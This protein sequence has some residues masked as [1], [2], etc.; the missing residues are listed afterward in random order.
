MTCTL[1]TYGSPLYAWYR[2]KDSDGGTF[3][4]AV[5]GGSTTSLTTATTPAIATQN[6]GTTGWGLIRVTGLVAGSHNIVF[7]VTSA[8]S[9]SNTVTPIAVGTLTGQTFYNQPNLFA[10]GVPKQDGDGNAVA[11][12]AYNADALSDATLLSGDGLP[13]KFVDVRGYLCTQLGGGSCENTSGTADMSNFLHPNNVGHNDLKQAWENQ[14]Q[15][16]SNVTTIY[17][18]NVGS[19]TIPTDISGYSNVNKN[20]LFSTTGVGQGL[21]WYLNRA[22]ADADGVGLFL[23]PIRGVYANTLFSSTEIQH[24]FF[25]S[26]LP[27]GPSSLTC[28]LVV[29]SN[30][31]V[32]NLT[33]SGSYIAPS[34]SFGNSSY[35]S[36]ANYPTL[37][38]SNL[39]STTALNAGVTLFNNGTANAWGIDFGYDS[40]T[41]KYET[42]MFAPSGN[43]EHAFCFFSTYPTAQSNFTC[44]SWI[45]PAS[46]NL[47]LGVKSAVTHGS[48]ATVGVVTLSGGTA[49]VTTN[50]IGTL[51][52]AGG[53]GD[54]II[55]SC[56]NFS[57]TACGTLSFG[58]IVSNVGFN[59]ASTNATDT[60]YWEIKHVN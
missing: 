1:K 7:T 22:S 54:V 50:Q 30:G 17:P 14:M 8:T 9:A 44:P 57:S 15:F 11:T 46:W 49:L 3:T 5:D 51:A 52:T 26:S 20:G 41:S 10:G 36:I 33:A 6:G 45:L 32:G 42:R 34:F 39:S 55:L 4:Y 16:S 48:N 21:L 37:G 35:A 56:A 13:I 19:Q 12:A 43:G 60:V 23:D 58:A 59:I 31:I 28:P 53:S 47:G 24:C 38:R 18:I 29:N 2:L 27:T 40:G 25:S